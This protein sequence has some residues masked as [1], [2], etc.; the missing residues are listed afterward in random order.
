MSIDKFVRQ[1]IY[2]IRDACSLQFVNH[3][4][5]HVRRFSLSNVRKSFYLKSRRAHYRDARMLAIDKD[6]NVHKQHT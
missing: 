3:M 2:N 6:D 1:E 5:H 4:S